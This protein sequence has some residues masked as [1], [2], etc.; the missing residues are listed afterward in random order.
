MERLTDRRAA[1]A[2]QSDYNRRIANGYPRSIPEER[3]LK[4]AAL[5]DAEEEGRLLVL[6][7]KVGDT[8][9]IEKDG[10]LCRETVRQIRGDST[11]KD[12]GWHTFIYTN[13]AAFWEGNIGRVVFFTRE[14]AEAALKQEATE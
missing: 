4:L 1:A 7:C 5:E 2:Q 6:P 3:Y 14:E 13:S 8:V 10:Q 12:D 9:W 11:G